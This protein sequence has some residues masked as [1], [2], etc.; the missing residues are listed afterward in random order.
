MRLES[1]GSK[2]LSNYCNSNTFVAFRCC[3]WLG[4]MTKNVNKARFY[5][6][7][8]MKNDIG[9]KSCIRDFVCLWDI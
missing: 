6:D 1:A 3:H 2:V 4:N 9:L 5:E 7:V 8:I